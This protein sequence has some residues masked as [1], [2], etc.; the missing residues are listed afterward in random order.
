[1]TA[2]HAPPKFRLMS[3]GAVNLAG[4]VAPLAVAIFTIPAL[5]HGL[6][7][8][9]FG[10]LSLAWLVVGY[11][12][13]FDLGLGRALTQL[14]ATRL[15]GDLDGLRSLIR[16]GLVAM[17]LLGAV[18][19]AIAT[20]LTPMLVQRVFKVSPALGD[21]G[22]I[23]FYL[24]ALTVP[25]VILSTGLIGILTAY[26]RF[27]LINWVRIPLGVAGYIVP[28]ATMLF[29]R[30][31]GVI[32]A[33]LCLSR[34][35]ALIAF[36]L[37][38][39]RV[40]HGLPGESVF[41]GQQLA[42][43]FRFGGWMTVTN[44]VGP[45]M[46]YLD[47]FL[48]GSVVSVAAVAYYATPFQIISKLVMVPSAISGVLFPA[49]AVALGRRVDAAV[50]PQAGA[51]LHQLVD[52]GWRY[53]G[54]SMFP[55]VL[56]LVCFGREGLQLWLGREFAD[57][58]TTVL[59][60]LA[61]GVFVN[62]IAYVP[63]TLIQSAGRA[64][65]AAKLHLVELPLYVGALFAALNGFG[66]EGAAAVWTVRFALDCAC[67]L[68]IARRVA[69]D[70]H[71]ALNRAAAFT[72]AGSTALM[73]IMVIEPLAARAIAGTVALLL[74][75]VLALRFHLIPP[76]RGIRKALGAGGNAA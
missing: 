52:R 27:G 53:I 15:G 68:L 33:L 35:M 12:T 28:V 1:M 36:W 45:V 57:N 64:D 19:A 42:A 17:S 34:L 21:E 50:A 58:G 26:G 32:V 20:A 56:M 71:Q 16:T 23:A 5:L 65:L 9:R 76:L 11:F 14:I 7:T 48:V 72:L 13:I 22:L 47:R 63:F 3:Q 41:D 67:L 51:E 46:T 73:M 25:V 38:C 54:L 4:Q 74:G 39:R 31:L 69:P 2:Q 8:E 70:S 24:L 43:L 18:G 59:H 75:M 37:M 44:L 60:W 10:F 49:F 40:T 30:D 62:A 6:G 55:M 66:I 29:T 61:L